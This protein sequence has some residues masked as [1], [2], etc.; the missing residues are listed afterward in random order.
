MSL[1]KSI[2]SIFESILDELK[3]CIA[4]FHFVSLRY[5]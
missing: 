5:R 3:Y 4:Y 2:S 1:R